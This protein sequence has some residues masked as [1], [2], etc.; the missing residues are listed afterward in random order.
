ML[1]N[2]FL[3]YEVGAKNSRV[4]PCLDWVTRLCG[5]EKQGWIAAAVYDGLSH[6][7]LHTHK[8]SQPVGGFP[9]SAMRCEVP[10]ALG[11]DDKNDNRRDQ[12]LVDD[13]IAQARRPQQRPT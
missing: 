3:L 4:R 10:S 6:R 5:L 1:S 7:F 8:P 9:Q 11:G 2:R 12:K 13:G